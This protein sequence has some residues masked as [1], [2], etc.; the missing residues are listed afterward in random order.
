[1]PWD[2][3]NKMELK[4]EFVKFALKPGANVRQLLR[5]Y[6]ISAPTGYKWIKRYR[7]CGSTGL[8][9]RSR[10]PHHQPRKTASEIE[11]Q[12]IKLRR[13][14]DYWGAR[15]LHQILLNRNVKGLPST[16]TVHNI[17]KRN[18]LITPNRT[19]NQESKR[20]ERERPNEL[21]QMDFKGWFTLSDRSQ[22]H[23]LTVCDD[24]SRYNILLKACSNQRTETVR[25]HLSESFYRYGLPDA[26][27]CDNGSP[28]GND[29]NITTLELW[30]IR[31]GIHVL[32]GRPYHPQTQG[33]EE[34]FHA[35]L[36]RELLK[37]SLPFHDQAHC[38]KH[39]DRWRKQYNELRPHE[40]IAMK[41]PFELYNVC[42]RKMPEN[43]ESP[44]SFYLHDDQIRTV[45]S[46]GEIMF[47]NHTYFIGQAFIGQ[48]V[49]LRLVGDGQWELFYCWKSLGF[50]DLSLATKPR[51]NYEKLINKIEP[52]SCCAAALNV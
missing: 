34:R 31:L 29:R 40:A 9:E 50:I 45:K 28:W 43:L 49:A 22:C 5:H 41:T 18:D 44:E 4:E 19:T 39:L 3:K 48:T 52:K 33:K 11:E 35:T 23:T 47:K 42:S 14:Y 26:I 7:E 36:D 37:R 15:K 25:S 27:L 38:Q 10:C 8:R 12:I 20:F 2:V 46:K 32:H 13:D 1:M 51:N 16:T 21:W 30:L 24:H 17:L 6:G